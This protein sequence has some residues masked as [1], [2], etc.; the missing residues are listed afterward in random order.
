MRRNAGIAISTVVLSC[1]GLLL[2]NLSRQPAAPGPGVDP[3]VEPEQAAQEAN[4]ER[5]KMDL[6]FALDTTG[7]M[8][9]LIIGAKA[10]IWEIARLAQQGRPQPELRVGLVAYRDRGDQ[11]VTQ[12]LALTGDL[13]K[14]YATLSGFSAGGGGDGPEH[15]LMGLH[16]AVEKMQWSDAPNAVRLVYLVGDAPPHTDYQDGVT[17]AG[18]LAAASKK[19]IR[20]NAVRCGLDAQTLA[21][22]TEIARPTDGEVAT[23]EQSGGVVTAATPFDEELA[24]LNGALA[25]TEVHYGSAAERAEA[26]RVMEANVAAPTPAQ[27]DRAAF[28]AA[29]SASPAAKK[30]LV[31]APT[32][33][34]AALAPSELPEAM[35]GMS[36]E[37]QASFLEG[38]RKER[39]EIL[40]K[41]RAA[42]EK[43]DAF[44]KSSAPRPAPSAFDSRVV[45][46]MRKAAMDKGIAY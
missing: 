24:R 21:A 13:D 9:G 26:E 35:K 6:V 14:V 18:V 41:V 43:R 28:Y 31:A 2:W 39:E 10:K 44:L 17:L 38:K 12:S 1:A 19:G 25:K 15:V 4:Q 22:F 36:A 34:A 30:D 29:A 33:A 20:I 23:I 46:S 7:S 11:Y 27:A 5:P 3:G 8:S 16:E 42:S 40:A 37:E 45:E 32:T